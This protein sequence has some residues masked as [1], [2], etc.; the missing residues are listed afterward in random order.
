MRYD[1]ERR[2]YDEENMS[3]DEMEDDMAG[4]AVVDDNSIF[5]MF[6]PEAEPETIATPIPENEQTVILADAQTARLHDGD[7]LTL[8]FVD[9]D[10][11]VQ[12]AGKKVGSLKQAYVKKLKAERGGQSARV[13]YKQTTPPMVRIVF[14]DGAPIPKTEANEQ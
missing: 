2:I 13:Y 11:T 5:K 7:E 1:D 6:I 4:Y 3:Q 9:D 14:G 10:C 8:L 12:A